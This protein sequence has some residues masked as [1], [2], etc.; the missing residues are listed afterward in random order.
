MSAVVSSQNAGSCRRASESERG[1]GLV[2]LLERI[3]PWK[4]GKGGDPPL[5]SGSPDP[6]GDPLTLAQWHQASVLHPAGSKFVALNQTFAC[7][8]LEKHGESGA[9]FVRHPQSGVDVGRTH[10]VLCLAS[11]AVIHRQD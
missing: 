7:H 5:L 4:G 6:A 10:P 2:V 3:L 9:C 8:N 1:I 11:G